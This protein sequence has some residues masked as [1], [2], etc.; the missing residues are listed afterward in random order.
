MLDHRLLL[1]AV[2]AGGVA[3]LALSRPRPLRADDE[4]DIAKV[5]R[6]VLEAAE[7]ELPMVKWESAIKDTMN[8]KVLYELAGKNAREHRFEIEVFEDGTVF[9]VHRAVVLKNVPDKV[10][11]ALHKQLPKFKVSVVFEVT[12]QGEMVGY[13]FEGR[14][15]KDK[16]DVEVL[17]VA[18][19]E[20]DKLVVKRVVVNDD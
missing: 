5:P 17:V 4:I 10:T 1:R 19:K 13:E 20:G 7:K 8:G 16:E 15:P 18:V 9:T 14:R 6:K 3:A 11:A 2:T 12:H